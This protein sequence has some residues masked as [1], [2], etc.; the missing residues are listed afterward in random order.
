M[1]ATTTATTAIAR[2]GRVLEH[3]AL[4]LRGALTGTGG[5]LR[6]ALRRDRVLLPVQVAVLVFMGYV[7]LASV[8]TQYA[9]VEE[10]L[11]VQASMGTNPAFLALLGP[12][13]HTESIGST[14]VWRIGLFMVATL[15]VLAVM[16]VV[17]HTRKEEELGRLELVRAARVGSLAPLATGVI[18]G[19]ILSVSLGA[20]MALLVLPHGPASGAVAFGAQFVGVG[21]ASVGLA[22]LCAQIATSSR[23][24]NTIGSIVVLAGYALRGVGDVEPALSWLQWLSPVGWAQRIDPYGANDYGPFLL[25]LL[26]L[27]VGVGVSVWLTTHRD[28]G[29]GLLQE[30]PGPASSSTLTSPFS[31]ASRLNRTQVIAW[32]Y[33]CAAYAFLVGFLVSSFDDLL[34][35]NPQMGDF[36]EQLGGPGAIGDVFQGLILTW[37]GFAAAAFGVTLMTRLRAE[38]TLGRSETMLA[39]PT[40]RTAYLGSWVAVSV[41]GV[42]AILLVSGLLMGVGHAISSDVG[43]G[44]AIG[45]AMGASAVVVPAALVIAGLGVALYG[46]WPHGVGL[47]WAIISATFL[48]S[49]LGG[50]LDLPEWVTDLSPFSHVPNVPL[51]PWSEVSWG[52][53]VVLAVIAVALYVAGFLGFRRRDVPVI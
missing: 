5:L 24:A 18:V 32:T 39:T 46:W 43:W 51:T 37:I 9:T 22:A 40:S 20:L 48:L 52:P 10:R 13:E 38:E 15:G 45:D 53:L 47:G 35:D 42:L 8:E 50:L 31:L 14:L 19:A 30:R 41:G 44:T 21:L 23:N 7:S 49:L 26:L 34:K 6:L 1:T 16:A 25:C 36:V 3:P 33:S 4:S 27:V 28:L 29:A 12:F 11:N 2:A 17:R